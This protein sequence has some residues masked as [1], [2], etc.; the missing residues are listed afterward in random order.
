VC[1]SCNSD[2]NPF[3]FNET[4][5]TTI[6]R[7]RIEIPNS[8]VNILQLFKVSKIHHLIEG[9][10][11]C[12]ALQRA[13]SSFECPCA[14]K[15][16]ETREIMDLTVDTFNKMILELCRKYQS[17]EDIH[18]IVDPLLENVDLSKW[19]IDAVSTADCFHPSE[20]THEKVGTYVWNNLLQPFNLKARFNVNETV[21]HVKPDERSTIK[22]D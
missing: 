11:Y 13:G 1:A 3:L 16:A 18:V 20:K 5:T 22:F 4:L 15:S 6:E 9:N 21:L 2:H 8:I 19:N 17:V 12:Q 14:Y 7:I 10:S